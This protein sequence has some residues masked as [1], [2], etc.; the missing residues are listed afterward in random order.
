MTVVMVQMK[1]I[2][3]TDLVI[4]GS[5]NVGTTNVS[6]RA[7]SVM[8]TMIVGITVKSWMLTVVSD[9]TLPCFS[10]PNPGSLMDITVKN[11]KWCLVLHSPFSDSPGAGSVFLG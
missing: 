10:L 6:R 2:V 4:A 9:V 7:G 11:G 1:R 8:G 3:K 5:L